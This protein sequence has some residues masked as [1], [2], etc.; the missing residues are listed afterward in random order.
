MNTSSAR[1]HVRIHSAAGLLAVI[2]HLLG[3]TPGNSLVVVGVTPRAAESGS[4]SV[5]T[6]PTR[7]NASTAAE[8][9]G[10]ALS[11]LVQHAPAGRRGGWVWAWHFS[12]PARR[13]IPRGRAWRWRSAA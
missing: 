13:R 12:H 4:R 2:P 1:P 3:F 6:C 11:V 10:H 5:T 9:A 8:I 7:P